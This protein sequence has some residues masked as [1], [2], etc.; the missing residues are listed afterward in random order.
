[1]KH[2]FDINIF[3]E[4]YEPDNIEYLE[5]HFTVLNILS[6]NITVSEDGIHDYSFRIEISDID[7]WKVIHSFLNSLPKHYTYAIIWVNDTCYVDVEL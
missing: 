2:F 7:V 6:Y 5:K 4:V 1:M 3:S